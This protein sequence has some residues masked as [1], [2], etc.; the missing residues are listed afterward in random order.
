M[1]ERILFVGK[2]NPMGRDI[3]TALRNLG[4]DCLFF[5]QR[6]GIS[7][8]D[9]VRSLI[10]IVPPLDILRRWDNE[11]MNARLVQ[12]AIRFKP[13]ILLVWNGDSISERTIRA[14]ADNGAVT[15]NWFLDL[16][17][18]WKIIER[19]APAY[20]FFFSPDRRVIQALHDIGINAL[21]ASFAYAAV[22][23]QY[24]EG[25]RPYPIS[26]VGSYHPDIWRQREDLLASVAD[27]GVNVWGPSAWRKSRLK[28]FYHGAARGPTMVEVYRK[29]RIVLDVPWDHITADAVSIRPYEA[30]A[31]GACLFFYDIRP[32]MPELFVPDFE[33]VPFR[34]VAELHEKAAYFLSHTDELDVIARA[35][36]ARFMRDHTYEARLSSMI[37]A[38]RSTA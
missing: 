13:S 12:T 31:S 14:I 33:Y 29:S 15:A 7:Y 1:S 37:E 32:E 35:G 6:S 10:R 8:W 34:T 25:P 24:P 5:D 22:F 20:D 18:H 27:L 17:T 9:G 38:I 3:A 23:N 11:R 19:V 4:H 36:H 28:N 2:D 30:T 26:F 16:M 21:R